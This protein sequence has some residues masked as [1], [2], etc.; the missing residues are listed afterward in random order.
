MTYSLILGVKT[1]HVKTERH[2]RKKVRSIL[3]PALR[4]GLASCVMWKWCLVK[5]PALGKVNIEI[6]I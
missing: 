3:V 1:I 2:A 4:A 5:M 6:M